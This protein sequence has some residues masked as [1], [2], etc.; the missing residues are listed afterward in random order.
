MIISQHPGGRQD[1]QKLK[2]TCDYR[3]KLF[4]LGYM[5]IY[6]KK[7]KKIKKK[8]GKHQLKIIY[9]RK[10]QILLITKQNIVSCK[11]GN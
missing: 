4:G 8:K 2:V 7:N 3:I 5:V 11:H 1:D 10:G 9:L 6:F